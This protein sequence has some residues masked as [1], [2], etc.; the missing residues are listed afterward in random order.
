MKKTNVEEHFEQ[1]E[2]SLEFRAEFALLELAESIA[3]QI[4][5]A[6]E[7]RGLSQNDLAKAMQTKQSQISRLEDPEY[8]RYTLLTLAKLAD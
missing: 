6:R 1:M 5:E 8:A 3:K 2:E 7:S 4:K